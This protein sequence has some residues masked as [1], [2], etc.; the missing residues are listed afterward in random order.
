MKLWPF[1][2]KQPEQRNPENPGHMIQLHQGSSSIAIGGRSVTPDTV[3]QISAVLSCVRVLSESV[4]SLSWIVY[5]RLPTGGKNRASNNAVYAL[6]HDRPNPFMSAFSYRERVIRDMTLEG[7]H[8]S[9]I[10]WRNSDPV[11]L[12]PVNPTAVKIQMDTAGREIRYMI[13]TA[14]G[15]ELPYRAEEVLHIPCMGDGI[16]GRSVISY[17]AG[18]FGIAA[19]EDEYAQTF[20]ANGAFAGGVLESEKPLSKDARQ[21][22]REG[23]TSAYSGVNGWHRVAVLEDGIEWKAMSVNPKDSMLLESRKYQVADI[24]RMFRV[25]LH[26]IGDLDR[27]TFSNIEHQSLEFVMHTLRPWCIRLEQ[28]ANFK[29][30]TKS[31]RT[32]LFSEFLLDSMLRGDIKSRNEAYAVM[33]QNGVINADE[34]R[35]RENMNPLPDGQGKKYI[36]QLNMQELSRV[37][38]EGE[39]DE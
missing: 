14:N 21:R 19:A 24:A 30:F 33:R 11:A 5:E 29:L 18:A 9:L 1:G 27:A 6:L 12:W 23:W 34:W 37:G 8:F 13:R 26:M 36:V 16:T 20:F 39:N 35:E 28:E 7:N 38:A 4:A 31:E 22:L 3:M 15:T 2:R 32:R 17:N 10:E 25:P